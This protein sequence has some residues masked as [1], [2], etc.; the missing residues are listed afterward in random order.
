MSQTWFVGNFKRSVCR[1]SPSSWRFVD[2]LKLPLPRCVRLNAT[3]TGFVV[4]DWLITGLVWPSPSRRV[5]PTFLGKFKRWCVLHIKTGFVN[6]YLCGLYN[7]PTYTYIRAFSSLPCN[8]AGQLS[9]VQKYEMV[10]S[11]LVNIQ[12]SH[13]SHSNLTAYFL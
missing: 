7:S 11:G 2:I 10:F 3:S 9:L 4:D 12:I 1:V 6:I 5:G 8:F 13:Q